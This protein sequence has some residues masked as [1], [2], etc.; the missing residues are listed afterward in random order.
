MEKSLDWNLWSQKILVG[1]NQDHDTLPHPHK[2]KID[3]RSLQEGDWFCPII[4]ENFD[5]HKFI[6]QAVEK[7]GSGFFYQSSRKNLVPDS[8]RS[9]GVEV[10]CTL[11]AIQE[12]GKNWRLQ[13]DNLTLFAI[14]G[15]V[16]KTTTKEMLTLILREA[17]KTYSS[18]G[19]F[20][21]EIGVA[22]NLLQISED[23]RFA[24]LEFGAR[25]TGDIKFLTNIANPNI[26]A[27]LNAGTAHVGEF[28]GKDKL[29]ETKLEI[30]NNGLENSRCV[31]FF[32]DE[33]IRKGAEKS[34]RRAFGFGHDI[35][36]GFHLESEEWLKD[37]SMIVHF[38]Q[39]VGDK[40]VSK[41]I[42]LG[43]S[44]IS[45]PI[46]AACSYAMALAA[47][48]KFD[49]VKEALTKF[50]GVKGR[51]Q[52]SRL[53]DFYL[54]D[55]CYNANPESMTAGLDSLERSFSGKDVLLI[56][57]DMLELG[58]KEDDLHFEIGK[59]VAKMKT[60]SSL[61]T[62]GRLGEMIGKGA[63]SKGFPDSRVEHFDSRDNA[64]PEILKKHKN[65]DLVYLKASNGVGLSKIV[66]K[67]RN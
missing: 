52:I 37:G 35:N 45:Y 57:G 58:D 64:L 44:H 46:N 19:N 60:K 14:T 36:A 67:I 42:K 8:L 17:G 39:L 1:S 20:N 59:N 6:A 48:I 51:Y 12:I 49:D 47:D 61:V 63:I 54:I 23:D 21:N 26:C 50:N 30:F 7:S 27:L 4:G 13:Q 56:L 41:S 28:G 53:K 15:S 25:H 2:I 66:D 33:R 34:K 10:N 32:D 29:C 22:L 3:S 38:S 18:I 16:G 24:I 43:A 40:K 55:D 62:I 11:E 5:G 31:Y 65:F 9:K